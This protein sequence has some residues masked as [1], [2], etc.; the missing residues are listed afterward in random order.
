[1]NSIIE[2]QHNQGFKDMK[3]LK[4]IKKRKLINNG[5]EF[6]FNVNIAQN[7]IIY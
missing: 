4:M 3:I 7:I 6:M 1:M 5:E 2:N